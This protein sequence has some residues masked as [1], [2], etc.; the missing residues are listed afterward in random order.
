MKKIM[1]RTRRA[2]R[3]REEGAVMIIT[4]LVVMMITATGAYAMMNASFEIRG[5]RYVRSAAQA[6][7]ISETGAF[8]AMEWLDLVGPLNLITLISVRKAQEAAT[9]LNF[10]EYGEPRLRDGQLAFRMY[11]ED[12]NTNQGGV[13]VLIAERASDYSWGAGGRHSA[14][15]GNLVV[16]L[17]D[18]RRSSLP[19]AGARADGGTG[20]AQLTMAVTARGRLRREIEADGGGG[21]ETVPT[22]AFLD[23]TASDTRAYIVSIPFQL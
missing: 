5:A 4:M 15:R 22:R 8:A 21:G 13:P 10:D 14:Q 11:R 9:P 17:T 6:Q 16:D 12:L 3:P 19:I 2:E 18:I 23:Q 1:K 20:L 7:Y